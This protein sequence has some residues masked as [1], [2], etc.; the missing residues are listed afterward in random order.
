MVSIS[1]GKFPVALLLCG[2]LS[3][4]CSGSDDKAGTNT[5][6][7]HG[8]SGAAQHDSGKALLTAP[9][10]PTVTGTCPAFVEGMAAFSPG[11]TAREAQIYIDPTASK[12]M[13]GPLVIY[14]Y[15]TGGQPSQAQQALGTAGI[16]R[17]KDAGGVVV[18]PKH[19]N[20][21]VFPWIQGDPTQVDFPFAD[22][23]VACAAEKV[24][25]DPRRVHS[26]GFSA[27]ALFTAQLSY[28]RSSYFASVATYSGGGAGTFSDP[29]NKFP[30]MIVFGG[31]NDM[32]VL[33]FHDASVAY[34]KALTDAGHFNFLCDHGGGHQIPA[35]ATASVV[36]F[37]FDHPYGTDPEPYV[38]GLPSSFPA[39]CTL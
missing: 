23:I 24:G 36:Q 9:A 37:F 18:A 11:G 25:I 28:A 8:D 2:A 30:A 21:G 10:L 33:N 3:V 6:N 5:P 35:T 12:A 19:V 20:A 13:H 32:L 39:Y 26:L 22:E 31:T 16:Q 7:D 34:Q 14:W 29:N 27:G 17:I 1:A 4:A 38:S 15:G